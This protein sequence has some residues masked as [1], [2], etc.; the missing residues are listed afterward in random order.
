MGGLAEALA[1]AAMKSAHLVQD[2][3][4]DVYERGVKASGAP[5]MLSLALF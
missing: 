2:R 3:R 5:R 1:L 4:E